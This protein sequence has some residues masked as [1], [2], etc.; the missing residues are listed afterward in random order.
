M[1][2]TSTRF[3]VSLNLANNSKKRMSPALHV[4]C[5]KANMIQNL[6]YNSSVSSHRLKS[7]ATLILSEDIISLTILDHVYNIFCILIHLPLC[8][9]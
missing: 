8:V 4:C 2:I 7:L 1:C 9:S 3:Y 5:E 6:E